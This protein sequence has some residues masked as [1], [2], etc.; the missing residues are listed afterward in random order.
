V[1]RG[2]SESFKIGSKTQRQKRFGGRVKT[3][4]S[5]NGRKATEAIGQ[6]GCKTRKDRKMSVDEFKAI[7]DYLTGQW[8]FWVMV[9]LWVAK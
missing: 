2:D 7:L 3:I 4:S 8:W 1:K 5:N 6:F 9:F